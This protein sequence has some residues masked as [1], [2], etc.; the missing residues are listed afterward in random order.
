M[1]TDIQGE[2]TIDKRAS[3]ENLVQ[4]TSI[5][6]KESMRYKGE[7]LV[8]GVHNFFFSETKV[9]VISGLVGDRRYDI[10]RQ[11]EGALLF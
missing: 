2:F 7:G 6:Y 9:R 3:L 8:K 11:L 10:G 1:L 4:K 5:P